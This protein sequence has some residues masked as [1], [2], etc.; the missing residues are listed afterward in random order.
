MT[1]QCTAYMFCFSSVIPIQPSCHRQDARYDLV[2]PK[3][4]LC[5][6]NDMC[7]P[8][9]PNAGSRYV[10]FAKA[11]VDKFVFRNLYYTMVPAMMESVPFSL[12]SIFELDIAVPATVCVRRVAAQH[13]PSHDRGLQPL[14]ESPISSM[15]SKLLP[16]SP[17]KPL[18]KAPAGS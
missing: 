4:S 7:P 15:R 8:H 17:I 13:D 12:A 9:G 3:H 2:G 5:I 14:R 11:E 16:R 10:C 6:Q 1:T 18:Q